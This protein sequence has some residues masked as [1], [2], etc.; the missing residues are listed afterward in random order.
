VASGDAVVGVDDF[1]RIIRPH[2]D[3]GG[4]DGDGRRRI[5]GALEETQGRRGPSGR[6][7]ARRWGP[8]VSVCVTNAT[9]VS[10]S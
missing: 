3:D 1:C 6:K 4:R 7:R 2:V 8:R 9:L 5:E 10:S